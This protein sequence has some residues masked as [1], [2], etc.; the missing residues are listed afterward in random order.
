L[1]AARARAGELTRAARAGNDL[2]ELEL[3]ARAEQSSRITV[4]KLIDLYVRRRVAG[5]LKS[6]RVIEGRL[7][8]ALAPLLERY[9][10]EIRRRDMRELLDEVADRNLKVEAA[11]EYDRHNVQMGNIAGLC[12]DRPYRWS[13]E[14]WSRNQ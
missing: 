12:D 14:L 13:C 7:R 6:A 10:D 9:A 8:R 4:G 3:A 1:D 11:T 5:R 2:L